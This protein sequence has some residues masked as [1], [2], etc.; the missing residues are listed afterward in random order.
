MRPSELESSGRIAG[1]F[2]RS[3]LQAYIRLA[4]KWLR[5]Y[6]KKETGQKQFVP[7]TKQLLLLKHVIGSLFIRIKEMS[8]AQVHGEVSG[9]P[10]VLDINDLSPETRKKFASLDKDKDGKIDQHEL[11]NHIDVYNR[12][13]EMKLLLKK[14]V[15][16]LIIFCFVLMGCLT[17]MTYAG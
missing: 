3:V 11:A 13:L 9:Q 4:A 12:D 16:L 6:Q 15:Y 1:S 14:I 17:Y 8:A 7:Q 10:D 2:D 5:V